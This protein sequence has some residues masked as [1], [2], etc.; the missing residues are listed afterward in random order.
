MRMLHE[1]I[2]RPELRVEDVGPDGGIGIIKI[3]QLK[4]SVIWS[5]GGGWDHVSVSAFKFWYLPSWKE[6][7]IIKD[8]FFRPDEWVVQYHPAESSYVNRKENCLH[9]WRPQNEKLPTPPIIFV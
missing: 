3:G 6:M 1:I 8:I 9:L 7:C 2:D 5:I 4:G